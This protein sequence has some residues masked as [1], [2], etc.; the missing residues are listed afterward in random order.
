M[1]VCLQ[2]TIPQ[3]GCALLFGWACKDVVRCLAFA[4]PLHKHSLNDRGALACH[5]QPRHAH[6]LGMGTIA[7][8][9]SAIM[10]RM[11]TR[12]REIML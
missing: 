10:G 3:F 6:R 12:L 8:K 2:G 7:R 9:G 11:D 5:T 1:I 4:L